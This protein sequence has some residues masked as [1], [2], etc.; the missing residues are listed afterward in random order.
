MLALAVDY[1]AQQKP[2]GH[3]LPKLTVVSV[4]HGLRAEAADECALVAQH[5][6]G[7]GLAHY[8]IKL[9]ASLRQGNLQAWA[10]NVR[11]Q[12]I[13]E[14]ARSMD[15]DCIVTAHHAD[16]QAE[17]VLLSAAR[18]S[19]LKGLSAMEPVT[20]HH[21]IPLVRP[22]LTMRRETLRQVV[23]TKG[24]DWVEDRSNEDERFDRVKIRKALGNLAALGLSV[25]Q[26]N[27][28]AERLRHDDQALDW[29]VTQWLAEHSRFSVAGL[30]EIPLEPWR[31]LPMALQRRVIVTAIQALRPRSYQ[32]RE[33]SLDALMQHLRGDLT[34]NNAEKDGSTLGGVRFLVCDE[35]LIMMREAGRQPPE[36]L[37]VAP[38]TSVVWDEL[39]T[40]M[41]NSDQEVCVQPVGPF[42]K[43]SD[44]AQQWPQMPRRFLHNAPGV[45]TYLDGARDQLICIAGARANA[46]PNLSGRVAITGGPEKPSY[47]V[48]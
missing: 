9:D 34:S 10:R 45:F 41:N 20:Y 17:T 35:G 46:A 28:T 21:G 47:L 40:V 43:H 7:L 19:G 3:T 1:C 11:Y 39:W 15:C 44:L 13:V 18:G 26:L 32:P 42:L 16:D 14:L 29:M 36:P 22:C 5:C 30:V 8:T 25:E 6:V 31:G 38:S 37:V 12:R 2:G 27:A 4:D 33:R 48:V 23:V 24:W